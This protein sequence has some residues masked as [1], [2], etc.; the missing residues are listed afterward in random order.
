MADER[1]ETVTVGLGE[2]AYDILIGPGLI[3][4]AG[5]RIANVFPGARAAIVTD[6]NVARKHLAA[7]SESLAAA[8]V[9]NT[10]VVLDPGRT[11]LPGV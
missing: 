7:L 6:E 9:A 11:G 2:R 3:A 1:I 4:G 5:S 8:D 10:P